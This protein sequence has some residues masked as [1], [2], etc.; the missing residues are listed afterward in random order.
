V[1]PSFADPQLLEGSDTMSASFRT[2]I[3]SLAAGL[4]CLPLGRAVAEQPAANPRTLPAQAQ[5]QP[6][7]PNAA[8]RSNQATAPKLNFPTTA[9][10]STPAGRYTANYGAQSNESQ[11]NEVDNY[12]VNCLL[13][14]NQAEIELSQYAAQQSQNPKVKQYAQELVKD[15][16]QVVQKLQQL[17][18]NNPQQSGN[19]SLDTAAQ[20]D[21]NRLAN[22]TTRTP[23]SSGTDTAA[24]GT[25]SRSGA[26]TTDRDTA[27][28]LTST[29]GSSMHGG[30]ELMQ[31]G[32]I[33]GKINDRYNQA[34]REELQQKSG[35]EFDDCYLGAQ[36]GGHMYMLAELEVLPEHTQG[37]LKQIVDEA[38]PTVQ[39]HLEQAKDLMK[40]LKSNSANQA[41]RTS[42]TRETQR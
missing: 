26:G 10:P 5:S 31:V 19:A 14:S 22:D 28:N 35:T 23:G 18:R 11:H 37:Q 41:E 6:N 15:H 21:A 7:D 4:C 3:G 34:I 29:R 20:N 27:E 9:Q 12:F 42:T 33:E 38:K 25:T 39:K 2:L 32:Q 30:A 24:A 36:I 17:A 16:Q 8:T 40:E 1:L 13:K